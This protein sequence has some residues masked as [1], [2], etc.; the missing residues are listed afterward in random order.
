MFDALKQFVEDLVGGQRA[1]RHFDETD[2]RLAAV[3]LLVHAMQIDGTIDEAE[4]AMLAELVRERYGLEAREAATLVAEAE[5]KN[6][7]AVD[8][9]SFTSVLKRALDD[10]GRQRVVKMLWQ[11]VYA[12]GNVHEFEDNLVWRVAELIGVSSRDRIR[13]RKE[14]EGDLGQD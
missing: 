6:A 7:E 9:Y 10:E 14:V 2:H 11:I 3:A 4:K 12:D 8:L 1:Q 5:Q 13:I